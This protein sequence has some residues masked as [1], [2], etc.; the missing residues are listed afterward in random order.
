[1]L[2]FGLMTDRGT[3]WCYTM[4][5][6]SNIKPMSITG[7]KTSAQWLWVLQLYAAHRCIAVTDGHYSIV[8]YLF[9]SAV[10]ISYL[11]IHT[12]YIAGYPLFSVLSIQG[13]WFN[14]QPLVC[15]AHD[16]SASLF[17]IRARIKWIIFTF[18]SMIAPLE[19]LPPL[20]RKPEKIKALHTSPYFTSG[21]LSS[22]MGHPQGDSWSLLGRFKTWF[23]SWAVGPQAL[24]I[25]LWGFLEA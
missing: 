9:C 12:E 7:R 25:D 1:M 14:L 3:W 10:N 8:N 19:D 15:Y 16:Y 5:N 17:C 11:K 21:F 24:T 20:D 6:V 2:G 22:E 23:T 4:Q 18:S 13:N